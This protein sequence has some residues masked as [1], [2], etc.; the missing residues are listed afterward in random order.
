[1]GQ[2]RIALINASY[3]VED[4]RRN[5]N[6]EVDA[7]LIEYVVTKGDIP[8]TTDM[9]GAIITGSRASVYWDEPWIDHTRE[10][11]RAAVD[12]E[13]PILGVCW[14]HQ[15]LA[16]A[17]GGEVRDMG[18]YEIGYRTVRHD[19]RSPLFEGIDHE[20]LA[21]QT[22][23]DEVVSAPP[24]T[25]EVA[26]SDVSIQSYAGDGFWGVQFHPEYDMDTAEMVTRAKDD[27]DTERKALALA[28]IT[29]ENFLAAGQSKLVLE[30]F[31]NGLS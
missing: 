15:L 23:S 21:F 10:W 9:D 19:G 4:T 1:M 6:R 3:E 22:H 8:T 13:V 31:V 14:G 24:G 18:E 27:L 28:S 30:N 25:E 29:R 7:S 12:A 11:T 20:F 2:P 17:L 16:D 5:F 26:V